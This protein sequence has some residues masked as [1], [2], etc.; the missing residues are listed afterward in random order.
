MFYNEPV[1]FDIVYQVISFFL[2]EK[3]KS[4][5]SL[6]LIIFLNVY[7]NKAINP[8]ATS[9]VQEAFLNLLDFVKY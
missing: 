4:R 2:N 5:V 8:N 7:M 9:V 6:F 1:I 3:L